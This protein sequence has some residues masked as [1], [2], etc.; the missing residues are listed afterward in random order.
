MNHQYA[1]MERAV[2]ARIQARQAAQIPAR[3]GLFQE[4]IWLRSCEAGSTRSDW[5]VDH[6][7]LTAMSHFNWPAFKSRL[8]KQ[9]QRG[10]MTTRDWGDKAQKLFS[11]MIEASETTSL[12]TQIHWFQ[13]QSP[14]KKREVLED[15]AGLLKEVRT[16]EG[17]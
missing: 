3:G 9:F 6:H 7:L 13:A 5:H 15:L 10:N 8:D 17:L 1:D 12:G 16:L 4:S 11:W 2:L 14:E